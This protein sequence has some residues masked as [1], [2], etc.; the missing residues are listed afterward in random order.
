MNSTNLKIEAFSK[1]EMEYLHKN[2]KGH[3]GLRIVPVFMYDKF[4]YYTL[5]V[6]VFDSNDELIAIYTKGF[7]EEEEDSHKKD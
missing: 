1:E 5:C 3:Y 2:H 7:L 4:D 6:D